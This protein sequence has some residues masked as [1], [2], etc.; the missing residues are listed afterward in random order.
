MNADVS[1]CASAMRFAFFFFFSSRRRHTRWPRDWSS[2][3]ALP[4]LD[5]VVQ[6]TL[7]RGLGL[8]VVD[9]LSVLRRDLE[10]S[11]ERIEHE[12]G[13]PCF[14][15]P[16]NLG[17]SVGVSKARKIGRASGRERVQSRDGSGAGAWRR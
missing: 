4:I 16:A 3:C 5:K 17:S 10:T 1:S 8:P 14:V 9:F 11:I 12:L 13:Y 6:K 2:D 15:K 7:W